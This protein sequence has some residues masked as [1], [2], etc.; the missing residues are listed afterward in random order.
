MDRRGFLK[1]LG[2]TSVAVAVP[3]IV[4]SQSSVPPTFR[5]NGLYEGDELHGYEEKMKSFINMFEHHVNIAWNSKDA[6]KLPISM[7]SSFRNQ[8]NQQ[9]AYSMRNE[10]Y[11]LLDGE[12]DRGFISCIKYELL[13]N[14]YT[15]SRSTLSSWKA[16]YRQ[17]ADSFMKK[18][19]FEDF[20][21]KFTELATEVNLQHRIKKF[22]D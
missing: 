21:N 12:V 7:Y 4:S 8:I 17:P 5:M 11:S 6:S 3:S 2:I 20:N 15:R 18:T 13:I 19:S 10:E 14:E 1:G 9:Y 22:L 16:C